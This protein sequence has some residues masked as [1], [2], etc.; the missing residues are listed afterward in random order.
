MSA[1]FELLSFI[2]TSFLLMHVQCQRDMARAVLWSLS[3]S[4]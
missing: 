2:C 4:K 3:D 1:P